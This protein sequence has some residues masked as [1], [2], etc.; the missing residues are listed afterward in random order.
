MIYLI[1]CYQ[2]APLILQSDNGREFVAQVIKALMQL[3]PSCVIVHGRARHPQTQGS[4]ERSNQD[5]EPMINNWMRDN[6][7][8]KWSLGIHFVARR[9]FE[10]T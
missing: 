8:T 9:T 7:T 1:I 4:I 3:W 6:G 5:I 10:F 2:G